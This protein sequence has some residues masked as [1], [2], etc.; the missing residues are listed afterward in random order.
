MS[1]QRMD[2]RD[3]LALGLQRLADDGPRALKLEVLCVA[4]SRTRGSF[5]HHFKDHSDFLGQ[6][7]KF[8]LGQNTETL[9]ANTQVGATPERLRLLA[10]LAGD[11]NAAVERG[12]RRLG[13]AYPRIQTVINKADHIRIAY[14]AEL[15]MAADALDADSAQ[16][17]AKFEYATYV[18]SQILW[19]R[20]YRTEWQAASQLLESLLAGQTRRNSRN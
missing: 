2:R 3:W 6:L 16:Q 9:I 8:W 15:H 1:K 19:G 12:M 14:L 7:A 18:G 4:A 11:V 20:S 13:A 17:F 10:A 5:Y